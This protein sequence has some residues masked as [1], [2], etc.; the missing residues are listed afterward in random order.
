MKHLFEEWE[1]IQNRIR[2]AQNLFL[3]SK[4]MDNN[5]QHI[6]LIL[7]CSFKFNIFEETIYLNLMILGSDVSV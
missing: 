1:H 7:F 3:F 2:Q 6:Y 5:N 4:I